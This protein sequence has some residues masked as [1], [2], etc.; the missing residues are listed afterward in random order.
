MTTFLQITQ[1]L[2]QHVWLGTLTLRFS[3]FP[4]FGPSRRVLAAAFVIVVE[5]QKKLYLLTLSPLPLF[6]Y[7]I[8]VETRK[9]LWS[10]ST[11]LGRHQ[12]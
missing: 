6:F 11:I 3:P 7:R 4:P 12:S 5:A 10:E 2:L 1:P 8:E 9:K